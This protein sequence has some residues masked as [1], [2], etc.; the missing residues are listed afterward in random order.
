MELVKKTTIL[1]PP[2]LHARLSR[3]AKRRRTSLGHLV[4]Q[5]CEREYAMATSEQR[6]AAVRE[7]R[8]LSL[9]VGSP[10]EMKRESVPK[11]R[12]LER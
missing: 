12:D 9:P 7:L 1:F 3:L 10:A 5:A 6:V 2:K 4:R 11:P 8:S